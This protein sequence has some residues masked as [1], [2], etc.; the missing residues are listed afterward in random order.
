MEYIEETQKGA[1]NTQ[2]QA[3]LE[4][5]R[6]KN[7]VMEEDLA[8]LKAQGRCKLQSLEPADEFDGMDLDAAA[9]VHH[10][11]TPGRHRSAH[12]TRKTLLRHG[13]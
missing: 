3:E 1:V 8:A 4:A 13:A 5:L 7:Q 10:D 2:M 11:A 6:A 9:R 12:S